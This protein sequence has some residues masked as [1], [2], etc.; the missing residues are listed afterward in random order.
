MKAQFGKKDPRLAIAKRI[1]E[2]D[3][4][5]HFA[6]NCGAK[7]CPPM[8]TF[9]ADGLEEELRIVSQAFCEDSDNCEINVKKRTL[10]LNKI[11]GWYRVDFCASDKELPAKI[12]EYLRGEKRATLQKLL[13]EG[14][15]I[16][17]AYKTYDWSSNASDYVPFDSAILR[18]DEQR[19]GPR[20][21]L[22]KLLGSSKNKSTSS[23]D[24]TVSTV[25]TATDPTEEYSEALLLS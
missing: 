15:P 2:P 13:D 9:T 20:F 11:L 21:K 3:C 14:K 25:A 6:L 19:F 10:Y 24:S 8:K 17:V 23:E 7:S 18:A 22:G 5:L 4:R 1:G 12:V 16:R